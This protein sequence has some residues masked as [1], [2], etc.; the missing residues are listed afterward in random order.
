MNTAWRWLESQSATTEHVI[1]RGTPHALV[2]GRSRYID[3]EANRLASE[4]AQKAR[5][6]VKAVMSTHEGKQ[7]MYDEINSRITADGFMV[8]EQNEAWTA[9]QL[10]AE[11]VK[12]SESSRKA[13]KDAMDEIAKQ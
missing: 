4:E 2:T 11:Q 1:I 3:P 5:E 12:D 9:D 8:Q 10:R 6:A 13:L 7:K